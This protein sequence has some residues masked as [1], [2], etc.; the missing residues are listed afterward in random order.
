ML[1]KV[2]FGLTENFAITNLP[3]SC[4]LHN[5]VYYCLN[6]TKC[7]THIRDAAESKIMFVI[8]VA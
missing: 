1:E 7:K 6:L 8:E 3:G 4:H 5:F 2:G